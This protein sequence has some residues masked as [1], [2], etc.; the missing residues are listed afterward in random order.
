MFAKGSKYYWKRQLAILL[1]IVV[2]A[3]GFPL[4][5]APQ[6]AN[7]AANGPGGVS[8]DLVSWFELTKGMDSGFEDNGTYITKL[9]DLADP[10]R[11]WVPYHT[12][13][14]LKL[15]DIGKAMINYHPVTVSFTATKKMQFKTNS[16][17]AIPATG[18]REVFSVQINGTTGFPWEF[19]GNE[20]SSSAYQ[21]NNISTHFGT[22]ALKSF[23]PAETI[24]VPHILNARAG[25]DWA[26]SINGYLE[27]AEP[28]NSVDWTRNMGGTAGYHYI[29]AAHNR[30][31]DGGQIAEVLV[32]NRKLNEEEREKVNS[33]LALKYGITLK[34]EAGDPAD[35]VASNGTLMWAAA[36][37]S[38]FGHRITGIG[39]D[40]AGGLEQT[41]SKSQV[42]G[43]NVA[44][45]LGDFEASNK[46][47]AQKNPI[48][49][50]T[51]FLTF[52]DN[53]NPA[54]YV[55][56]ID[57]TDLP[58]ALKHAN[59]TTQSPATMMSRVYK[60]EKSADWTDAPITLQVD[61]A[62]QEKYR[63]YLLTSNS[64]TFEQAA[65]TVVPADKVTGKATLNSSQLADGSYFTFVTQ[66]DKRDLEQRA[67]E[68]QAE[69][70]QEEN[71]SAA[72]WAAFDQA[73]KEAEAALQNPA[74][75]QKEVDDALKA[76][77]DARNGL[78]ADKSALQNRVDELE[79]ENLAEENYSKDSWDAFQ[80]ALTHAEE[81]LQNP[82]ATQKEVDEALQALNEARDGLRA[83]K[84]E[85]EATVN[86]ID[87]FMTSGG[88]DE[89][90]YT[91]ES[92]T[93]FKDA[94]QNAQDVL[95][96]PDATQQEIDEANQALREAY[97]NLV[98]KD[99]ILEKLE[100]KVFDAQGGAEI[101]LEPPFDGHQYLNYQAAVT[102]SVYSA[103]LA[104]EELHP[105]SEVEVTFHGQ[106][107]DQ[108]DDLQL[109]PGPNEIAVTVDYQGKKNTYTVI[110]Y[111]TDKTELRELVNQ[112][113]GD[114]NTGTLKEEDYTPESWAQFQQAL[115]AAKDV[116]ENKNATQ[117]EVDAAQQ[118]LQEA[119]DRLVKKPAVVDKSELQ[120]K[121]DEIQ[122]KKNDGSLK[123][124]NY[125][126]DS[127]R[128]LEEALKKAEDVLK[129]PDATQQEINDAKKALE[130]A[131]N[132]L[133]PAT[134]G[135]GNNG[136]ETPVTNPEPSKP[137]DVPGPS[138]STDIKTTVNGENGSFAT[139]S[140]KKDGDHEIIVVEVDKGKL[141]DILSK[142]N[143]QKLEIQVPGGKDVEVKGL[144]AADVKKLADTGSTLTIEDELLAIYP[145][146]SKQ[147]DLGEIAKQWN[148]AELQDIALNITIKRTSQE[149]ADSARK[150]A[151]AKG[152]EHLLH[153]V[154]LDM[155]F[156]HD[157]KTVRSEQLNG[158][159]PK[160]IALPEGID[161]NRI[162][163]GVIVNPDG[164]VY[165]V[166]T[167]VTK[168]NNRYF[169]LI[170]DLRSSGTYSVIWNPQDFE[171]VQYHW[172][173]ADVNNIAARLDLKGNG[174][175]TFS[176]NRHVTRSEFAEIVVL[177]LGLMRQ[178]APQN[179]YPDVPTTAWYRNAVAL[180][181]E[182]DIVRG[183]TDGNFKGSQQITREQ[184]FAM[185]ARAY[186][187]I[188]SENVPSQEEIAS[189]LARYAD[190]DKVASWAKGDVA[191][192][193]AAGIIQ[194]NGPDH[195]SPKAQMTRAEVTALIA[196]M[197]KVTNLIDK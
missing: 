191:Q 15:E 140:T 69:N 164:S 63:I 23:T 112:V 86:E 154:D 88:Y 7:A 180:A 62:D 179:I 123:E 157:G 75:T 32:F 195:L 51:T 45:A 87:N 185:I 153:P 9:Q 71:Y 159:A 68:I 91:S 16:E 106:K 103:K 36:D 19:G 12:D 118:A 129:K 41:Q 165:H 169:A 110:I 10:N 1:S 31:F 79:A 17:L 26:L 98:T 21:Q 76:L 53:G 59:D 184:G 55:N 139:G 119:Q 183:Y 8:Q 156:T 6:T 4:A 145:V 175:N 40:V 27:K 43:A 147:L 83:D 82:A 146:P 78:T 176:P 90:N 70:L 49:T 29:G 66:V 178:D 167:V 193:I 144:T 173:R 58:Q 197:L 174:D 170:N 35:Y 194:G 54:D 18:A 166:P 11:V 100:L 80:A 28:T 132:L 13:R 130:E 95:S 134:S 111:K 155:T 116:L 56:V 120:Q 64:P 143:G 172:G 14:V 60:V 81:V 74:A 163:T 196:R 181:D 42:E 168:V 48:A 47:N 122:G 34:T 117:Q 187:L 50:D 3:G 162:T 115:Q 37:N 131:F 141:S 38:G 65:V 135:G 128:N 121:V 33:Y 85:L 104:F 182:F 20:T 160:Y 151:E 97:E 73:L 67:N 133:K 22:S 138:K 101:Q 188:Q 148:G 57:D 137:S 136:G 192:L 61:G 99:A 190:G 161:P 96:K 107:V 89:N 171:D 52:S 149:L 142:G 39:K 124:S 109:Q 94:L 125:T 108:W 177:G 102:E 150:Q 186:R 113:D 46:E 114:I 2:V 127:W 126:P 72:S 92:L 44:I 30:T 77:D 105:D 24:T 158:Y 25:N 84:T 5:L 152:Y 93:P 189:T